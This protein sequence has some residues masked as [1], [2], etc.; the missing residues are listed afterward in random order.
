[1]KKILFTLI[2]S[3]FIISIF[4]EDGVYL[5][6]GNVGNKKTDMNWIECKNNLTVIGYDEVKREKFWLSGEIKD[7]DKVILKN[8]EEKYRGKISDGI[9]SGEVTKSDLKKEKFRFEIKRDKSLKVIKLIQET[10]SSSIDFMT[11]I[12]DEKT[13]FGKYLNKFMI[14]YLNGE[15]EITYKLD[16]LNIKSAILKEFA[17]FEKEAKELR[18]RFPYSWIRTSSIIYNSDDFI[19]VSRYTFTETGGAHGMYG[20]TYAV[21]SK[22][23]ET[24]E[25]TLSDI[26]TGDY[27]EY[28]SNKIEEQIKNENEVENITE[29]GFFNEKIEITDNF[30][31]T[32]T[33]ITFHYNPYEIS[34]FARGEVEFTIDYREIDENI[35]NKNSEIYKKVIIKSLQ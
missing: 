34:S 10:K 16:E 24:P 21:F 15:K 26:F 7:G 31:I 5:L 18:V 22:K 29:A 11:I 13:P 8:N 32:E 19:S 2:Y 33:G 1:M 27:T 6:K 9:F 14:E 35:F 30:Y 23:S 28:L 12:G 17:K 3:L 4:G 20:S 25:I